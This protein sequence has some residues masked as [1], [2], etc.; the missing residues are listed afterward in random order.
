MKISIHVSYLSY[1]TNQ[2]TN[3][4][5]LSP[6][7]EPARSSATQEVPKHFMEPKDSTGSYPDADD[8]NPYYPILFLS[9]PF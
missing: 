1:L 5:E 4:I 2:V 8:F 3:S 7:S 9:D 6:S